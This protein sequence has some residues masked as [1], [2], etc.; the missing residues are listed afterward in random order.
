MLTLLLNLRLSVYD[1]VIGGE[2]FGRIM[3]A[4]DL[5][6]VTQSSTAKDD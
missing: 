1:C 3:Y 4:D 5:V 6:L 2:F